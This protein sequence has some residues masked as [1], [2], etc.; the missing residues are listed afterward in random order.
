M[1]FNREALCTI[2]PNQFCVQKW[3]SST[4]VA[5][6]QTDGHINDAYD[7]YIIE[8]QRLGQ[9]V[10]TPGG[11]GLLASPYS[12]RMRPLTDLS[13]LYGAK[14][15]YLK[16][17]L[18]QPYDTTLGDGTTSTGTGQSAETLQ[19]IETSYSTKAD[20]YATSRF[21]NAHPAPFQP[22]CFRPQFIVNGVNI[23]GSVA[24]TAFGTHAN[25]G[26]LSNGLPL[27]TCFDFQH[28]LMDL[29]KVESVEVVGGAAQYVIGSDATVRY[30][31]VAME[32]IAEFIIV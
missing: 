27:Y 21:R 32:C 14:Q 15:V 9:A 18:Y 28:I 3:F 25:R 31:R 7:G 13:F 6:V 23:I 12:V 16:H 29:E 1:A 5:S 22:A 24:R 11:Q 26:D 4:E 19:A 2:R 30:Q 20:A 17:L 8:M 10:T